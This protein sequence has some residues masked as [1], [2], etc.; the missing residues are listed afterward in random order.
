LSRFVARQI[1]AQSRQI[2]NVRT[3]FAP[4]HRQ[5]RACFAA[6]SF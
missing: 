1:F 2:L 4:H 3:A 6:R 5:G